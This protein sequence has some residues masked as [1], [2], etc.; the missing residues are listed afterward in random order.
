MLDA[1]FGAP[2]AAPSPN[3]YDAGYWA[4]GTETTKTAAGYGQL[5]Y[6]L[7]SKLEVTVGLREAWESKHVVDGN[8]FNFTQA[9]LQPNLPIRAGSDGLFHCRQRL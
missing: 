9:Y 5:S 3:G 8:Q 1:S 2:I 6:D 4:G 7:T